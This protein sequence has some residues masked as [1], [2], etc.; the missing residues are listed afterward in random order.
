MKE[1]RIAFM[2]S[3]IYMIIILL[4]TGWS[5]PASASGVIAFTKVLDGN[6][7]IVTTDE[8]GKNMVNLSNN[9]AEDSYPAWSHDGKHVAFASNRGGNMDI[10]IMDADGSNQ[11]RITRDP[12]FDFSPS[13]AP[14]GQRLIFTRMELGDVSNAEI[15][16]IDID[17]RNEELLTDGMYAE[18]SPDGKRIAFGRR[19]WGIFLADPDGGNEL[20]IA[21]S[22]DFSPSWSPDGSQIV[23]ASQ[24]AQLGHSKIFK[25]DADGENIIQLTRQDI[26]EQHLAPTYSPD[27]QYIAFCL[28]APNKG[29]SVMVMEADGDELK[30]ISQGSDPSWFDPAFARSYAVNPAGKLVDTWGS[31]KRR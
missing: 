15:F 6:W 21:W 20:G 26:R 24:R 2:M 27:G 25:M 7:E 17:G 28:S 4:L 5:E 29:Y 22:R 13:F 1:Q 12:L 10:Y 16:V 31:L 3:S 8:N 23:F 9:P 18:W 30:E 11:R 14:D 19:L